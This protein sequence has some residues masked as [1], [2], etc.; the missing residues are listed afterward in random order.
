MVI[1]W[2]W[3]GNVLLCVVWVIIMCLDFS[4]LCSIFSVWWFYLGSL[5]RKRML[6]CVSE[7]L[8]GCGCELLFISDIVLVV[9]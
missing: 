8:L 2:K 5:L 3:V 1:S 6:L 4:G 7:I 9:W